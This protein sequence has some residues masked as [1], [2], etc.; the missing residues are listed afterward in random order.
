MTPGRGSR[1]W[2][3]KSL[4]QIERGALAGGEFVRRQ[5]V[6][7]RRAFVAQA[8]R[9]E[10]GRE[11]AVGVI[12]R[13]AERAGVEE[14]HVAGQILVLGAEAVGDPRAEAGLAGADVAGVKLI[15]GG[16]VVVATPPA[17]SG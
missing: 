12:G 6:E 15:A 3:F 17:A 4:D 10:G 13:A 2:R 14:H 11:E 8:R 9:L 16:R 1:C 7:H 5:Q